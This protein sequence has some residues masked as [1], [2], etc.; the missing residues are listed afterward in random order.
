MNSP[1]VFYPEPS[2][3][4]D[5]W[6]DFNKIAIKVAR[7]T[8]RIIVAGAVGYYVLG[9]AYMNGYM[10]DIDKFAML[11]MSKYLSMGYMAIG[12]LMPTVQWYAA[13][14]VRVSCGLAAGLAYDVMERVVISSGSFFAP[15]EL[16]NVMPSIPLANLV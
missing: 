2:E 9:Y 5:S 4:N 7:L 11:V 14:G 12:A 15:D 8:P 1:R 3:A 13:W 6:F 10:A 16:S